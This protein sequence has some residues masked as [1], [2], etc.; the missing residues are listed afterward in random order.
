MLWGS[1]KDVQVQQARPS[2]AVREGQPAQVDEQH[3]VAGHPNWFALVGLPGS[4]AL[5]EDLKHSWQRNSLVHSLAG[6]L[7]HLH[8]LE[9]GAAGVPAAVPGQHSTVSAF[10][11]AYGKQS[12][13][14]HQ[15]HQPAAAGA[16]TS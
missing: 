6:G 10:N 15:Q 8:R 5:L 14:R 7:H 4:N 1:S 16:L 12:H 3:R 9:D 13:C 2:Y 11:R